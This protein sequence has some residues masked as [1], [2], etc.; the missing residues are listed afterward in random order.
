MQR[1]AK[2]IVAIAGAVVA[3]ALALYGEQDWLVLAATFITAFGVYMV[4]NLPE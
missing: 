3:S 4:P 1:Y 2:A